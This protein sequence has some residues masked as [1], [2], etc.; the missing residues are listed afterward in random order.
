MNDDLPIV[1]APV[2]P[3]DPNQMTLLDVPP[4]WKETWA[5]MPDFAQR[6][7][8]PWQTV[9]VHFANR[10]DRMAFAK[11]VDQPITDDTKSLWY[12]KAVIAHVAEKRYA[13]ASKAELKYPVYIISKSR[14][15]SRLTSKALEAIHVPY[16]IVVE[17]QE[18][19]RYAAVIDPAKILV[20]PFSNLGLGSI[21]ARNWVWQ[22]SVEH[23][24]ERHWILDDNIDG[25]VRLCNNLKVPVA[26]GT[27]F[28]AAEDF[29]DRYS[30][31]G[32]SGFNYDFFA[33]RKQLIPPFTLNT[34]IYSCIL[35]NNSLPFMWRGRYNEDTDLSLRVLKAGLCTILFN[36][37]LAC[38]MATMSMKGGNTDE[39]YKDDGRLKM[40]ES[41]Q[42]QHPDV[43]R[44]ITRWGRAQHY[45]HYKIFLKNKLKLRP[46]VAPDDA[47]DNYGMELK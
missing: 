12:P 10:P 41:L 33:K 34:R 39:L 20:L 15:E 14:W 43:V 7:L 27:I 18:F 46:G 21:P 24:D 5:G 29:T 40:A 38:K 37:F 3:P 1:D 25:F 31:V 32:L 35:V 16:H 11:L 6:N 2:V 22:H 42:A 30:N 9:Q 23:E 36:A 47:A 4:D 45:V 17:P 8:M 26:D 13:G 44:I 19:D 28:R